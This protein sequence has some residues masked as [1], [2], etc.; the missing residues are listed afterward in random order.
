MKNHYK[1]DF[2]LICNLSKMEKPFV[3]LDSAATS[4][5]PKRVIE[6]ENYWYEH[7][8]ANVHGGIYRLAEAATLA[9]EEVRDKLTHFLHSENRQNIIFT[10]GTTEGINLVAHSFVANNLK[11]GDVILLTEMEHHANIVP[12]QILTKERGLRLRFLPINED[13]QLIMK[14]LAATFNDV[15]FF[16]FCHVS[17]VLGTVNPVKK[18]V[19]AAHA[20]NIPVL[21]DGAQA[22]SH[23]PVNLQSLKPDFYVFSGHKMLGPSGIGGLYVNARHFPMMRPYQS[24]GKMIEEVSFSVP[25]FM[26]APW[27]FEAGT[28][29]MSQVYALGAAIDYLEAIGVEKIS[30]HVHSLVS[31]T[32][33]QLS[34]IPEVM[35]YGPEPSQRGSVISFNVQDI[36]SHDL[37]TL[38]D[39]HGICIRAGHHCAQP[40]HG[41]FHTDGSAR[42]SFHLYNDTH[43]IDLFLRA[44]KAIIHQWKNFIPKKS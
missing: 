3:Y 10:K 38:L 21:V 37:A 8:N 25:T 15:K 31:M 39:E 34:E 2:P 4:Q 27:K 6:A 18:L 12:W 9:F 19:A 5:K 20:R 43:D 17:N 29:P 41:K 11:K 26:P 14:D 13:G 22:V 35:I 16:S 42:V 40:V 32:Y 24:G 7:L 1:K 33:D 36:P 28:Q 44:L 30:Q 23:L